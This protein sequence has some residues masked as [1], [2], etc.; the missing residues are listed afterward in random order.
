MT[1]IEQVT[2]K[3]DMAIGEIRFSRNHLWIRMDDD[4]RA[5]LGLTDYLQEKLGE[6]YSLPLPEEGE[7]LVKEEPFSTVEA[8]KGRRD[9][10]APVSGEIV[11]LNQETLEVPEIVNE[12]PM[13][14]GWLLKVEISSSQEF[15]DLLTEDEYEDFL[16]EE[17][18]EEEEED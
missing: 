14:E 18:E 15:D 6:I 3:E 1:G 11:E 17:E 9:L 16:A 2:I 7:E 10:I 12:D 5:T 4:L 13:S 8:K